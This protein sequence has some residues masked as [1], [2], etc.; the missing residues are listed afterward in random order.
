MNN[1]HDDNGNVSGC[2][3]FNSQS[4]AVKKMQQWPLGK[5]EPLATREK[6]VY[7]CSQDTSLHIHFNSFTFFSDFSTF[8]KEKKTMN[9]KHFCLYFFHGM[10]IVACLIIVFLFIL[11]LLGKQKKLCC[12]FIRE[13]YQKKYNHEFCY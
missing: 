5:C 1:E 4:N 10:Y 2:S 7:T 3:Q 13:N 9:G 6:V 11:K 8:S 12:F